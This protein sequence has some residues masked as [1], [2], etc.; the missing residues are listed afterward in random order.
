MASDFIAS[1]TFSGTRHGYVFTRREKGTGYYRDIDANGSKA[2]RRRGRD[3][4]GRAQ[5]EEELGAP[6]KRAKHE[7]EIDGAALLRQA[8]ER[9][10]HEATADDAKSL[11]KAM[12][13]MKKKVRSLGKCIRVC[14]IIII[15]AR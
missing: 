10:G 11:R 3:D 12:K 8:E 2:S 6:G 9:S 13:L 5:E 7:H 1:D 4:N 14:I 15:I